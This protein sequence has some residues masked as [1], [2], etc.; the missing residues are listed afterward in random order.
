MKAHTITDQMLWNWITLHWRAHARTHSPFNALNK[1]RVRDKKKQHLLKM[2][3][4]REKEKEDEAWI[5]PTW[6]DGLSF[7]STFFSLSD[8]CFSFT[9]LWVNARACSRL[10][11]LVSHCIRIR[12]FRCF[13][14]IRSLFVFVTF[15]IRAFLI[16]IYFTS[17][18]IH[19]IAVYFII[20]LNV[21]AADLAFLPISISLRPFVGFISIFFSWIPLTG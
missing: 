18:L 11:T 16:F 9:V 19:V 1:N 14:F 15:S 10:F 7:S 6:S 3:L 4:N 20:Q 21:V 17:H 2:K 13:N 8:I 5:K 12:L